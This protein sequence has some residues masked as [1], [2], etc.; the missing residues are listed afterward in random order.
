MIRT[1]SMTDAAGLRPPATALEDEGFADAGADLLVEGFARQL[2]RV[3]DRWRDAGFAPIASEY[4]SRLER[5]DEDVR[6]AIGDVGDLLV[7]RSGG[8]VERRLLRP[9]LAAPVWLDPG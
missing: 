1:V 9:E 6:Y 5:P 4:A 3:T 7:T 8:P 2:L